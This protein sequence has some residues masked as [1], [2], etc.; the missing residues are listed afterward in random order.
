MIKLLVLVEGQTEELFVKRVLAPYLSRYLIS[1]FPKL[2]ITKAN[3]KGGLATWGKAKN[4]LEH[5][6]QSEPTA[7]VTT[8]FD[9]YRFPSDLAV[10]AQ[11]A[12]SSAVERAV[13]IES[14]MLN[15]FSYAKQRF[16]PYL[17]VH[18]FEALLFTSP[19]TIAAHFEPDAAKQTAY[20]FALSSIGLPEAINHG[21]ETHPA[22]RLKNMFKAY[23][24]T[25]DGIALAERIGIEKML[26]A[27]PHF[28]AWISNLVASARQA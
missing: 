17:M 22:K 25:T 5:L 11:P 6:F 27:C 16:I 3:F 18:E 26:S 2:V 7:F 1:C 9:F 15:S 13:A 14:A 28:A 20:T 21:A 8:M 24:K 12:T 23:G 19:E 10:A 4:H